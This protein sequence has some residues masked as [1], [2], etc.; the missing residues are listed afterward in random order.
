MLPKAL[1]DP[2]VLL[3]RMFSKKC[4]LSTRSI[5]EYRQTKRILLFE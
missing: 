3:Q 4:K 1:A 2:R 5:R